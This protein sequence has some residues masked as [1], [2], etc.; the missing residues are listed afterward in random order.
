LFTSTGQW[1]ML[2]SKACELRYFQG[3]LPILPLELGVTPCHAAL[4]VVVSTPSCS[5]VPD[6]VHF[7]RRCI[8][9][10]WVGFRF[11]ARACWRTPC[12]PRHGVPVLQLLPR[13]PHDQCSTSRGLRAA[14]PSTRYVTQPSTWYVT[15]RLPPLWHASG[16]PA[17]GFARLLCRTFIIPVASDGAALLAWQPAARSASDVHLPM[18]CM[19]RLWERRPGLLLCFMLLLLPSTLWLTQ[20]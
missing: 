7:F 6:D 8:L 3:D 11:W 1:L 19:L 2:S 15:P 20:L 14:G 12:T 4:Q 18:L 16:Q 13:P 10:A 5:C 9:V 17:Y